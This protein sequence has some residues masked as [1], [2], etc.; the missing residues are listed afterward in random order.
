M[1]DSQD[2]STPGPVGAMLDGSG[3]GGVGGSPGQ[4]WK[5]WRKWCCYH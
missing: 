4:Y 3:Q 5:T 2:G 1:R